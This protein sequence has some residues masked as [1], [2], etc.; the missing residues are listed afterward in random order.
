MDGIRKGDLTRVIRP[1]P[2]C[3]NRFLIDTYLVVSE[4]HHSITH[5]SHCGHIGEGMLAYGRPDGFGV[6]VSRLQKIPPD[7]SLQEEE[8]EKELVVL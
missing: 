3:G 2:C 4:V 1:T 5:C 7:K 8:R 6:H